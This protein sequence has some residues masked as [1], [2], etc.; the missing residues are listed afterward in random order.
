[1]VNRLCD[2][3]RRQA[4]ESVVANGELIR[5]Q[6]QFVISKSCVT[7]NVFRGR[8]SRDK[9]VTRGAP[10]NASGLRYSFMF[11]RRHIRADSANPEKTITSSVF[12]RIY[13]K[14]DFENNRFQPTSPRAGP[15]MRVQFLRHRHQEAD[16]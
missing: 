5:G 13:R 14:R 10:N 6:N 16:F 4:P 12:V 3:G 2:S 9:T 7:H 15:M 11:V 1:M 8:I